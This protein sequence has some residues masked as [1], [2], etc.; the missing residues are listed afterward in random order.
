MP[1][2][3]LFRA[4]LPVC[5]VILALIASPLSAAETPL[6]PAGMTSASFSEHAQQSIEAD[7]MVATLTVRHEDEDPARAA[8]EVN[9]LANDILSAGRRLKVLELASGRYQTQ[10]IY[11]KDNRKI[12]RWQVVHTLEVRSQDFE[13]AMAFIAD[14]QQV[15]ELSSLGFQVS[16]ARRE[17]VEETLTLEAIRKLQKRGNLIARALEGK[18]ARWGQIHIGQAS[19]GEPPPMPMRAMMR[20]EA[21]AAPLEVAPGKRDIRLEARG[22]ACLEARE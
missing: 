10:P 3:R 20:S 1:S 7:T 19:G 17:A 16:E 14:Q 8:A 15:A 11:R 2:Y 13:T 9:A 21:A 4:V 22:T 18:L 6:C 5:P 12:D